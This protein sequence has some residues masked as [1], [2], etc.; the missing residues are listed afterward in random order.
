MLNIYS[1]ILKKHYEEIVNLSH[2]GAQHSCWVEN[3]YRKYKYQV[4]NNL[5]DVMKVLLQ[6]KLKMSQ[7]CCVENLLLK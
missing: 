7:Q 4:C 6:T 1:Y 3:H 5:S 2:F